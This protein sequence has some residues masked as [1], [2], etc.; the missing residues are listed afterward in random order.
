MDIRTNDI[1]ILGRIVATTVESIVADAEQIYDSNLQKD[2][3]T[4][5]NRFEGAI[6]D[7]Y[8]CT[9]D[10]AIGPHT[11]QKVVAIGEN[12][13]GDKIPYF[14]IGRNPEDTSA[15]IKYTLADLEIDIPV[16]FKQGFITD[17]ATVRA[18]K[19]T[20]VSSNNPV[21]EYYT[22]YN[23]WSIGSSSSDLTGHAL[24]LCTSDEDEIRSATIVYDYQGQEIDVPVALS[25][26]EIHLENGTRIYGGIDEG[27]IEESFIRL[28]ADK[29]YLPAQTQTSNVE[30]ENISILQSDQ[31]Q[32]PSLN[33][34]N[35]GIS[36]EVRLTY[37]SAPYTEVTQ[38]TG[39]FW[40]FV[41]FSQLD[42]ILESGVYFVQT[43]ELSSPGQHFIPY[44]PAILFVR[45]GYNA[46][47]THPQEYEIS[48]SIFQI[49]YDGTVYTDVRHRNFSGT[50]DKSFN[51]NYIDTP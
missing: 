13:D 33:I 7:I 38:Y 21:A 34:A 14:M 50:W 12:Q 10:I 3:A 30:C 35:E 46:T 31:G 51:P 22:Q 26:T 6:D 36:K 29:I 18:D 23:K 16:V 11:T 9:K 41:P 49:R 28:E 47:G 44:F 40:P 27:D 15:A 17:D 32:D 45:S 8:V 4:L 43:V 2:Q 39:H 48:Q 1:K 37:G 5:N 20:D 24:T 42:N 19:I 25:T